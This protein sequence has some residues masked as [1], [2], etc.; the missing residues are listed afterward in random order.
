MKKTSFLLLVISIFLFSHCASE[1]LPG[2]GPADTIPP[3]VVFQNFENGAINIDPAQSLII[4]FSEKLNPEQIEKNISL[5]PLKENMIKVQYHKRSIKITPLNSW[6][7]NSLYTIILEKGISDLRGNSLRE[8]FQLTFTPG[9][10]MPESA[11][12]GKI[13]ELPEKK[14]AK[15]FLSQ[16]HQNP[17]SIIL[18]PDYFTQS[19]PDGSFSF[20]HMP[21]DTFYIAAYVDEDKS[22]S[23]KKE[24]DLPCIPQQHYVI[25]DTLNR[26]FLLQAGIDNFLPGKLIK[27]E[28]IS[29]SETALN[30]TKILSTEISEDNF[31][32]N[33]TLP[34]TIILDEKSVKLYHR[35]IQSDTLFLSFSDLIDRTDTGLKDSTFNIPLKNWQDN[36]FHFETFEKHL[37][38]YPDPQLPK[39]AGEFHSR[40]T[41]T[42]ELKRKTPG[43]YRL[44]ETKSNTSGKFN[45][46]LSGFDL[47]ENM[48]SDSLYSFNLSLK[49]PTEYGRVLARTEKKV[50]NKLRFLLKNNKHSYESRSNKDDKIIIE[51]VIP[52]KYGLYYYIDINGNQKRDHGKLDPFES[53]EFLI[54]LEENIDVKARW[55]TELAY[56]LKIDIDNK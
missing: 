5:F 26:T 53:P 54:F 20:K 8:P 37:R 28:S 1:A 17:D 30:F 39:I 38:I 4:T 46:D 49:A 16:Y 48:L 42:I 6:D 18:H 29:P 34:D 55:D 43:F 7:K 2:G 27:A 21:E 52:G 40:D 13:L 14:T 11:I 24:F 41:S 19:G 9:S 56:P 12:R 50:S 3:Q 44:P 47:A 45:L 25:A 23:Y 33:K 32:I 15:I 36:F 35:E 31:T 51:N 10:Y 22:N